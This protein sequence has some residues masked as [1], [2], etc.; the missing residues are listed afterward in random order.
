V[1]AVVRKDR[2]AELSVA[3]PPGGSAAE[4]KA[5]STCSDVLTINN[6]N[7]RRWFGSVLMV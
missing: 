6:A 5:V 1:G 3:H 4:Q 7:R 2:R